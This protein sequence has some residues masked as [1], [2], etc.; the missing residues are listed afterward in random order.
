MSVRSA[1]CC[2]HPLF[3][4]VVILAME[5]QKPQ[6]QLPQPFHHNLAQQPYLDNEYHPASLDKDDKLVAM[7][8]KKTITED[9]RHARAST[10]RKQAGSS[11]AKKSA[12]TWDK[13]TLKAIRQSQSILHAQYADELKRLEDHARRAH[14]MLENQSNRRAISDVSPP[15]LPEHSQ[16]LPNAAPQ[17]AK[18]HLVEPSPPVQPIK[19]QWQSQTPIQEQPIETVRSQQNIHQRLIE[20]GLYL[21][22]A[23]S[24]VSA[25]EAS[26][27]SQLQNPAQAQHFFNSSHETIAPQRAFHNSA[28]QF[29]RGNRPRTQLSLPLARFL[30]SLRQLC[31]RGDW[32]VLELPSKA[33]DRVSNATLW[34]AAFVVVRV[35]FRYLLA[36]F[37]VLSPIFLVLMVAPAIVAVSLAVCVPKT[38]WVPYYRLFLV[39][40][41]L[42]MG[43]TF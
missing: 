8:A 2:K 22:E 23:G 41:G 27:H 25:S 15:S 21:N 9:K 1:E 6:M 28:K 26:T 33:I 17:P 38:S 32:K 12:A 11:Q 35:A 19:N 4:Q 10:K 43:G 24:L 30:C 34:I 5:K 39:M 37:P 40:V 42:F 16:P 20:L 36:V 13:K 31:K 3:T 14:Q 29:P 7:P 18:W